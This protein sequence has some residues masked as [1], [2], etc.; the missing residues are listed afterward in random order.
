MRSVA[1]A[2]FQFIFICLKTR[3]T[4]KFLAK[5][6]ALFIVFLYPRFINRSIGNTKSN[7]PSDYQLS[8]NHPAF[9]ISVHDAIKIQSP[10]LVVRATKILIFLLIFKNMIRLN[11]YSQEETHLR[12]FLS[13]KLY[14]IPKYLDLLVIVFSKIK[15][16]TQSG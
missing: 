4:A 9:P 16:V 3:V 13:V 6:K 11:L 14:G 8:L 12:F 15:K 5:A 10:N 7:Y 2:W 1:L